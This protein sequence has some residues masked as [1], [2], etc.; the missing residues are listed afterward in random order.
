MA[1]HDLKLIACQL[2]KLK[3]KVKQEIELMRKK[4]FEQWLLDHPIRI[5]HSHC[6]LKTLLK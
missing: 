6:T 3:N 5:E 4:L 2:F 1:L